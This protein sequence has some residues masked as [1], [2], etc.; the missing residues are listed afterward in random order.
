M[1]P[2]EVAAAIMNITTIWYLTCPPKAMSVPW[3]EAAEERFEVEEAG[4]ACFRS[5]SLAGA[6][7]E[8][9]LQKPPRRREGHSENDT[10]ERK[11]HH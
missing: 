2:A 3:A 6:R 4:L 9:F 5:R 1:H 7:Q 11:C 10:A 8:E